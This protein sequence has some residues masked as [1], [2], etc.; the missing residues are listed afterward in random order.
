MIPS[1]F[2]WHGRAGYASNVSWC[3][4][5]DHRVRCNTPCT[6]SINGLT[7]LA[8]SRE[9]LIEALDLMLAAVRAYE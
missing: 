1:D 4:G 5:S 2:C 8:E 7:L 6:V 3:I 9:Q